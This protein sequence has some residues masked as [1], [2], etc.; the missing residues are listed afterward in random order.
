MIDDSDVAIPV[1]IPDEIRQWNWGAFLLAPVWAI[2]HRVFLGLLALIPLVGVIMAIILGIKGNE[3]A[4][5]RKRW[6]SPTA[7]LAFQRKWSYWGWGIL[8]VSS[9][10]Y[11]VLEGSVRGIYYLIGV[12]LVVGFFDAIFGKAGYRY[13]GGMSLLMFVPI[14]NIAMLVKYGVSEWPIERQMRDLRI[15]CGSGTEEDAYSL[16]SEAARLEVKG[17]LDDALFKYQEVVT[18]FRDT[19]AG[20]DAQKSIDILK[21]KL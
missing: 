18:R 10:V 16:L 9:L 13:S 5:Q 4:W 14:A 21:A 8:I 15:R 7:F 17:K 6:G 19:A 20:N 2:V 3:W 12:I 11:I 1:A